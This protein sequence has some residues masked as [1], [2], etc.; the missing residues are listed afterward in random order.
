[1]SFEEKIYNFILSKREG[2]NWDFKKI[3]HENNA[4]LLHDIISMANCNYKDDRYII[5]GVSDPKVGCQIVGLKN[6]QKDRKEQTGIIDLLRTKK[7][8]GNIRPEVEVR[9]INLENEEVDVIVILNK[10]NKPYYLIEDY[11]D[12][13]KLVKANYIYTRIL[14]TNTPID[15][16]SDLFHV[17]KMWRERFGLD[18]SPIERMKLLLKKPEEWFKDLGNKD[19][20]YH[21]QHPEFRI[22]FSELREIRE[23]YSFFYTNPKSYLGDVTFKYHSTTLFELEYL[24]VD[25]MRVNI[26]G[27]SPQ[28]VYLEE[29]DNWYY[30]YDLSS[31]DGIFHYFVTDGNIESTARGDRCQFLFFK[32]KEEQKE[33][34]KYLKEN[35]KEFMQMEPD[36]CATHAKEK[37]ERNNFNIAVD[38][39]FINKSRKMFDKWRI[40]SN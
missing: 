39:I 11:R 25:E 16:S 13:D 36:F 26:G 1:M 37:M 24:T 14:D 22:E 19:Y 31:L 7:F 40:E 15:K 21:K 27:P 28:R 33:F 3:P 32:N 29:L 23:V 35:Q 30:Y 6:G 17:E 20:A 8:A 4:S 18:L 12:R 38:P 34:D 5:L 10:P 2:T 9:A